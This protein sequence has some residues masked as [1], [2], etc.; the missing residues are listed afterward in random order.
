MMKKLHI[1]ICVLSAAAAMLVSCEKQPVD[2]K[3]PAVNITTGNAQLFLSADETEGA[4]D[5][6]IINPVMGED[7][8]VVAVDVLEGGNYVSEL[9]I[10]EFI[11]TGTVT[12]SLERNTD[13]EDHNIIILVRYI[14]GENADV[15]QA[16][17][18]VV[19]KAEFAYRVDLKQALSVYYGEIDGSGLYSYELTLGD[20]SYYLGA[21][22]QTY[23]FDLYSEGRTDDMLPPEGTY[24]LVNDLVQGV[25]DFTMSRSY[26]YYQRVNESNT[27][28][29]AFAEFEAGEITIAREGETF[30]VKGEFTDAGGTWHYIDYQGGMD[31]RDGNKLSSFV[32]D[33]EL[34]FTGFVGEQKCYADPF[35]NGN[36]VWSLSLTAAGLPLGSPMAGLQLVT[37]GEYNSATGLPTTVFRAGSTSEADTFTPGYVQDGNLLCCWIYTCGADGAAYISDPV[38]PIVDGTIQVTNNGD[39]T[40]DLIFNVFD[41][42]GN[43]LTGTAEKVRMT[44]VE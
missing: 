3:I 28:L 20:P 40:I 18:T 15:A 23:V 38:A 12:F 33:T 8:G 17:M 42:A 1:F 31:A 21:N 25:S 16:A 26:S 19:H 6:E 13:K 27:D 2:T 39:G 30:T 36:N 7:R 10:Q 29:D 14:Y 11:T 35:G 24:R 5:Y 41:D 4:F 43:K 34:D 9:E 32:K 22:V 37:S 44:N